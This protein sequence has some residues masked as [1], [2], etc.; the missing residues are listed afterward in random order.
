M[1]AKTLSGNDKE[2]FKQIF[3]ASVRI[4]DS[5]SQ[6]TDTNKKIVSSLQKFMMPSNK[7][8]WNIPTHALQAKEDVI[9]A[10]KFTAQKNCERYALQLVYQQDY[11]TRNIKIVE[12][13]AQMTIVII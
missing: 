13:N 4:D 6:T 2:I 12:Q 3:M 9:C 11:F 8:G 1:F 10:C 5:V 7:K